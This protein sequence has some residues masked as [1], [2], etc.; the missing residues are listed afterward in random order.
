[1]IGFEEQLGRRN[2]RENEGPETRNLEKK[3]LYDMLACIYHLPPYGSRA[4]TR[5][6]LLKVH[7]GEVFTIRNAELKHFEADLTP[8]LTKRNGDPNNGLLV[9]KLNLLLASKGQRPLGFSHHDAPDTVSTVHKI[10]LFRVARYIDQSNIAEFFEK[11]VRPEPSLS[12]T[13][14]DI[15]HIYFGR[16]RASRFFFQVKGLKTNRKFWD[17]LKMI[18]DQFK[19]LQSQRMTIEILQQAVNEAK[20][21]AEETDRTL[22]NM[23]SKTALSYVTYQHPEVSADAILKG[24]EENHPEVKDAVQMACKL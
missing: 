7:R 18:S 20:D 21:K 16:R 4:V 19:F 2:P 22:S 8:D 11:E 17:Q 10:W 12:N 24:A 6:Y 14:S 3:P 1:M 13:S 23:V 9:K 5:E 15:S